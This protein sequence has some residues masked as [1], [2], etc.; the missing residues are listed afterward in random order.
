LGLQRSLLAALD[1]TLVQRARDVAAQA[2]QGTLRRPIPS[3][4]DTAT[5]QLLNAA[6]TPVASTRDVE[7]EGA[8]VAFPLPQPLAAGAPTTLTGLPVGEGSDYRVV[9]LP[10]QLDGRPVTVIAATSLAQQQRSVAGLGSGLVLSIPV[11]VALV[12][13]TTWVFTGHTLRP[14]AALRR[15]VDEISATD[16]H[17]RLSLP[18]AQDEIHHLAIT[19]N[20]MLGRLESA[21]GA[22][23]R[24]VADAAH[25]LRSPLTAVLAEVENGVRA[26]DPDTW[27]QL[28]PVLLADLRRL[29][30]LMDDLL[31]LARLDDP[32]HQA[33]RRI[34]DLDDVV[35]AEIRHARQTTNCSIDATKVGGARVTAD[36]GAMTR[37][38][39][40]LIDNAARHAR[41]RL[42]VI[43][44]EA[45]GVVELVVADDGPGIPPEHRE[46]VFE[47]FTRLDQAR[48]R[49]GGGAGLGLAIVHELIQAHDGRVWITAPPDSSHGY[50]G[51]WLHVQLPV[52]PANPPDRSHGLDG[53]GG[54]RST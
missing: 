32:G 11:L 17:R 8:I 5:V 27:N 38:V 24:F 53:S 48:D 9:A 46:R 15:D 41:A 14:V 50:P 3:A 1:D 31:T 26:A 54:W 42:A 12:S 35:L 10:A 7:G 43:L 25:E 52:N 18:P 22:Q 51:A 21:S 2:G 49:D 30:K 33:A 6:G 20:K 13:A 37:V 16:L 45:D 47:R 23:R 19:L 39:R 40:N 34:V 44:R 29:S 4:A 28:G 36:P